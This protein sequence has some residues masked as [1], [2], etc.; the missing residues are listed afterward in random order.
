MRKLLLLIFTVLIWC[1]VG[2]AKSLFYEKYEGEWKNGKFH[3]TGT[4]EFG[5]G[6]KYSG[7]WK[8]DSEHGIG[9]LFR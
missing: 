5:D 9:I 4:F 3:G 1:N 6:T 8:N 2:Y 7:E